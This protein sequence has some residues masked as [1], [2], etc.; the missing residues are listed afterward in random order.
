MILASLLTLESCNQRVLTLYGGLAL[1]RSGLVP[2]WHMSG[3]RHWRIRTINARIEEVTAKPMPGAIDA[4]TLS[5][6]GGWLL[7][8]HRLQ[9][10]KTATVL[11]V[12][13]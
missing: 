1:A 13:G 5:D 2:L 6:P 3:L 10:T 11:P 7:R 9:I 8:A 4:G 12:S